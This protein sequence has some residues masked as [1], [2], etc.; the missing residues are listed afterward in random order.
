MKGNL[1]VVKPGIR[2]SFALAR[3]RWVEIQGGVLKVFDHEADVIPKSTYAVRA[4]T[5]RPLS[6]NAAF[7]VVLSAHES[8]DAH[9]FAADQEASSDASNISP[10]ASSRSE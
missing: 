5:C 3:W 4:S 2:A 10:R 7:E 6:T 8:S 9:P 1:K